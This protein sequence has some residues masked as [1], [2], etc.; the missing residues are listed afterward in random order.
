MAAAVEWASS[1]HGDVIEDALKDVVGRE[2][3]GIGLEADQ[4]AM[5]HDVA[6][7]ALDVVGRHEIAAGEQGVAAG[8]SHQGDRGSRAGA[9]LEQ[10]RQRQTER[11]RVAGGPD[12]VDDVLLDGRRDPD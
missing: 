11:R 3:L 12:Q 10:R 4:D 7:Q 5:A 8:G 6:R 1:G 2:A 9:E